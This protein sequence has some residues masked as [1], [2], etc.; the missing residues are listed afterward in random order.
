MK[1][2]QKRVERRTFIWA[3]GGAAGLALAGAGLGLRRAR[4]QAELHRVD[5]TAMG[6]WVQITLP[7]GQAA[8]AAVALEELARTEERLSAFRP[9]SELGQLNRAAR[10]EGSFAVSPA[11]G[12][13]IAECA[14]YH[15]LTDGAFDPTVGPLVEAW[16]FRGQPG[17]PPRWLLRSAF[18]RV[19]LQRLHLDGGRLGFARDGM[20]LDLGGIA[21]GHG[22]DRAVGVLRRAGVRHGLINAAGDLRAVGPRPDGSPWI[23]G[24]PH[25]VRPRE[26]IAALEL[27]GGAVTTS[28]T[29][30]K[31][32]ATRGGRV[33]HIFDP[34]SGDSPRE[35]VS[36]TVRARSA[37]AA[38]A[39]ATAAV[40]LGAD[41]ALAML[42]RVP[43]VEG[44]LVVQ[45]P[46]GGLEARQTGGMRA[47]VLVAL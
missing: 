31:F 29:Y 4:S 16:G 42:E 22:V 26:R 12:A 37:T 32:V 34:R 10:H 45:K 11:L 36:A 19:G 35:V 46:G 30:L 27:R 13:L 2:E 44:F 47:R 25:P 40:V 20:S 24:V 8:A 21:V 1:N 14:G 7:A 23:I 41:E 39:L 17:R 28:G 15:R 3:A 9:E 33:S 43:G 18:E 5:A 6:S 38:D